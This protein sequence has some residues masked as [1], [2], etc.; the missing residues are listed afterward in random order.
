[1]AELYLYTSDVLRLLAAGKITQAESFLKSHP[2][3]IGE[4]GDRVL[5]LKQIMNHIDDFF[6]ISNINTINILFTEKHVEIYYND[7]IHRLSYFIN[8]YNGKGEYPTPEDMKP[9]MEKFILNGIRLL[10]FLQVYP[11]REQLKTHYRGE[12]FLSINK[13]IADFMKT[14]KNEVIVMLSH[15]HRVNNFTVKGRGDN[16]SKITKVLV[17]AFGKDTPQIL[18]NGIMAAK[19]AHGTSLSGPVELR[20]KLARWRN[21]ERET[22][23]FTMNEFLKMQAATPTVAS[24]SPR[25]KSSSS[26]RRRSASSPKSSG[27]SKS[28]SSTRRNRNN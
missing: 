24:A 19:H 3:P 2:Q 10:L 22:T 26:T 6:Y 13:H 4:D 14:H 9:S 25:S 8:N 28:T 21:F 16:I 1:M 15:I 5:S 17:K 11:N 23:H 27:S 20:H 7:L 12:G 18:E